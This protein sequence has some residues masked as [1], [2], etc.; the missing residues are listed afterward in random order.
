[1]AEFTFVEKRPMEGHEH[2]LDSDVVVGREGCEVVLPDPEVSR[3]HAALRKT[4]SGAAVED[5][6]S[7]N[8]TFVNGERITGLVMLADGDVVRFGNTEWQLRAAAGTAAAAPGIGSPQVTAA[9]SVPAEAPT[10]AHAAPPAAPAPPAAAPAAPAAPA[11]A[12]AQPAAVPVAAAAPQL[13]DVVGP[14]LP[15][16]GR[17]GDVP[18]PP[19][20]TPSAIRRTLPAEAAA[21]PPQFAP[22]NPRRTSGSAATRGGFTLFCMIVT[23]LVVA[24]LIIYFALQ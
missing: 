5:L 9:R 20:V 10:A 1:M 12:P 2:A 4:A 23:I 15:G 19:E 18:L 3:R 22:S 14:G 16:E 8:G 6:G 7:T 21:A 11:A 24:G 13:G 17:R